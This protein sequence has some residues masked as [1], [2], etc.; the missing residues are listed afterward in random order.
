MLKF[1]VLCLLVSVF[2]VIQLSK[3]LPVRQEADGNE[4]VDEIIFKLK[5]LKQQNEGEYFRSGK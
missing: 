4:L 3:A 1:E 2:C 5:Q